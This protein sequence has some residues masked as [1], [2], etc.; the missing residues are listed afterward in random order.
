M[1]FIY[2]LHPSAQEDYELSVSWYLKR[3]L[4]AANNFVD[5][6]DKT[7]EIIC[8]EPAMH[9]NV[10]KNYREL[11]VRKY[12]FTIVYTIE[13]NSQRVIIIAIYHHKRQPENKYR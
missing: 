12:P 10:Y 3:S 2:R 8:K 11:N 6:V 13:E 4:V 1:A 5:A 7:L 9:R